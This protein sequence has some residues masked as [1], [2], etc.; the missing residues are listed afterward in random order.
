MTTIKEQLTNEMKVAMKN[1]DSLK[2]SSIRLMLDRIQKK[3]KDD[4]KEMSD[5]DVIQVLQTFK[6][7]IE[8]SKI[9][10]E[11]MDDVQHKIDNLNRE[12][13]V[14]DFFLPQ[15]MNRKEVM[16]AVQQ[17]LNK[18]SNVGI[19]HN[20]GTLMKLVMSELKGKADNKTISNVVDEILKENS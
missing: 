1:K 11:G 17:L 8:E 5:Q 15:Q 10:F 9:Y 3:E 20:K 16:E 7:Q 14:V 19:V 6:K 2:L 18:N 12:I 13:A 4:Q